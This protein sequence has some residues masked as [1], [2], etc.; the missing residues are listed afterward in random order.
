MNNPL[1]IKYI[2]GEYSTGLDHHGYWTSLDGH[3]LITEPIMVYCQTSY[4]INGFL[5]CV[6][7]I[8]HNK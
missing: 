6:G 4:K 5:G 3:K 8:Y 1:A 2:L 7:K